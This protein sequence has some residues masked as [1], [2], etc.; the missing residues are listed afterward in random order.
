MLECRFAEFLYLALPLSFKAQCL[1]QI[2]GGLCLAR[3][4]VVAQIRGYRLV[5]IWGSLVKFQRT[6]V[7]VN[8][9]VIL[10]S[11]AVGLCCLHANNDPLC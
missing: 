11:Y 9:D 10:Y 5:C 2:K 1:P 7:V 4:H 6:G 8:F 3:C